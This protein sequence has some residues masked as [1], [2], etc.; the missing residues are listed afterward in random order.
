MCTISCISF[1]FFPFAVLSRDSRSRSFLYFSPL[2]YSDSSL[3]FVL[4]GKWLKPKKQ[5]SIKTRERQKKR[6][7]AHKGDNLSTP[8][9]QSDLNPIF[10]FTSFFFLHGNSKHLKERLHIQCGNAIKDC[11]CI[12]CC[13]SWCAELFG[14]DD[15]LSCILI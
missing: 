12:I 2:F 7:H 11:V 5:Q 10:F 6:A 4:Y 1:F 14:E 8:A 13:V 15:Y 3:H 9:I